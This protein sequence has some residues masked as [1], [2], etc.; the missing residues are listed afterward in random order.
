[1]KETRKRREK[2][3]GSF[4]EHSVKASDKR[5]RIDLLT[6]GFPCQPFS[7]AGKRQG[8]RDDRFLWPEMLRVIREIHPTW[9]I[10]E[11][12]AGHITMGLDDVLSDLEQLN[13][14]CQTFVVPACAVGAMQNLRRQIRR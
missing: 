2:E 4:W 12:V 14:T 10:G 8:D 11:N 5:T 9:I 3:A 6:G 13:Y 1:R 7:V